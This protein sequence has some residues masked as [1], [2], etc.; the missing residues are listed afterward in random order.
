MKLEIL[1]TDLKVG[2]KRDSMHN[3]RQNRKDE[4]MGYSAI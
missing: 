4:L 3:I 1:V 2:W